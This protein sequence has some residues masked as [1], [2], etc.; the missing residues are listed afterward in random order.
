[1]ASR[2]NETVKRAL[3]Q[4][5]KNL[6]SSVVIASGLVLVGWGVSSSVTGR[7]ALDLPDQIES[8]DPIRGSVRV[9][10]QSKVF[11]DL[12]P[13][14][15]GVLVID[16]L[17]IETVDLGSINVPA[18]QQ[19]T[20]PN[21]TIYEGGNATLTYTPAEGAP[22]EE[23]TQGRHQ[24]MVIYWKIIDGRGSARSYSWDFNVF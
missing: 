17:E 15:T 6:L 1:V 2:E 19:V 14:Y 5:T 8:V 13:G 16:G 9:P 7:E 12:L 4:R 22:I 24:A 20:L 11:V 18:G 23:F 10:A 21:A 3:S